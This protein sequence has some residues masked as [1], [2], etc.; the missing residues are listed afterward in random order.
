MHRTFFRAFRVDAAAMRTSG[1]P[2]M[3]RRIHTLHDK[4]FEEHALSKFYQKRYYPVKIGDVLNSRYHVVCKLGFGAYSTI[5]L[6]R[7]TYTN[8]FTSLKI[9]VHDIPGN[10][11]LENEIK[12]LRHLS[13]N[14]TDHAGATV[15]R[16]A[17]DF[18]E[19]DGH[20][21]MAVKPEVC[22]YFNLQN[23]FRGRRLPWDIIRQVALSMATCVNWLEHDC[24]VVHTGTYKW[25]CFN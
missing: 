9:G 16:L 13:S 25:N 11:Q 6:A 4:P 12:I 8:K 1:R 14:V 17:D 15:A 5:W 24:S 19:I 23:H 10:S 18:F 7:D 21:C 3:S 22:S 2:S 20:R